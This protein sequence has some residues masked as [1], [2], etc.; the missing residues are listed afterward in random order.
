MAH[1]KQEALKQARQDMAERLSVAEDEIEGEHVEET[2]FPDLALGASTQG[3]MSGQMITPG[4]RI[5][6]RSGN[7]TLEYRANKDQLRLHN[8]KG[9][10]HK[11]K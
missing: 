11:V 4:W 9:K 7:Q 8:Y 5:K 2:D 1:N 3:E 10:N 6:L